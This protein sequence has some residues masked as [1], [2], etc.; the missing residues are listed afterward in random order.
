[1]LS[2]IERSQHSPDC[3]K[4]IIAEL[5]E[6]VAQGFIIITETR[7]GKTVLELGTQELIRWED[8]VRHYL[9]E[10][11]SEAEAEKFSDLSWIRVA[12]DPQ[13]TFN[14]RGNTKIAFVV[15]L[16]KALVVDPRVVLSVPTARTPQKT[17]PNTKRVFI[18]HGHDQANRYR[19]QALLEK[20]FRLQP[21]ILQSEPGMSRP[22]IQ[23][24]EEVA[25]DCSF[26][27]VLMTPDDQVRFQGPKDKASAEELYA[28]SRPNV[29]FELGW[30]CGH[31]G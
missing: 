30:F 7:S 14:R 27:F 3:V 18:V 26:A 2:E 11:V 24:F 13:G 1:V 28:Q 12:V 16:R 9:A 25:E 17:L 23:K 19:L 6:L 31:I 21:I 8:R 29:I 5:D 22:L 20:R 10:S 15:G 4:K